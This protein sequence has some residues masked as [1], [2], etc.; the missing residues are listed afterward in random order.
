[1]LD[2]DRG[3][4]DPLFT[5]KGSDIKKTYMLNSS[6]LTKSSLRDGAQAQPSNLV[7]AIS[8][9]TTVQI[10]DIDHQSKGSKTPQWMAKNVPNDEL[11]L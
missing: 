11:D 5:M 6:A 9:G 7:A 8:K 1:M 10:W 2:H 3:K 4:L